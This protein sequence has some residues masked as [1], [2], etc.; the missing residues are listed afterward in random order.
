MDVIAWKDCPEDPRQLE[1]EDPP[2]SFIELTEEGLLA[3]FNEL[4]DAELEQTFGK[5]PSTALNGYITRVIF[6]EHIFC[7]TLDHLVDRTNRPYKT[8]II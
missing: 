1:F 7:T 2:P 6:F 4:S 8:T 3:R 5:A